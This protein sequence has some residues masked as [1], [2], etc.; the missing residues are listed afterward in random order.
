[1][2][3]SQIL[4]NNRAG[5]QKGEISIVVS[6]D[7]LFNASETLS[8]W[9]DKYPARPIAEYHRNFSKINITDKTA[10]QLR[11][12][13]EPYLVDGEPHPDGLV[14]W[15]FIEPNKN[16]PEWNELYSTGETTKLFAEVQPYLRER[17]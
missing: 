17:S 9:L 3:L 4:V 11:Y 7:H 2:I 10:D 1:M 13:Y 16:S 15:Y 14:K 8:A 5:N 12:L 6:P